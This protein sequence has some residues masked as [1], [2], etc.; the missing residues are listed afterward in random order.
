LFYNVLAESTRNKLERR[1]SWQ[2]TRHRNDMIS[3]RF[4]AK[5]LVVGVVVDTSGSMGRP[6]REAALSGLLSIMQVLG[7]VEV[8]WCDVDVLHQAAYSAA[9]LT[10]QGGGGTDL[11]KGIAA[12]EK[13]GVDVIVVITDTHTQW[14]QDPPEVPVIIV[15]LD[16]ATSRLPEY[17]MRVDIKLN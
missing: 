8:F 11:R 3:P 15:A 1:S 13:H 5:G 14:P 6:Q 9:D 16:A 2:R 12:A 17:A 4:A 10:P 7:R